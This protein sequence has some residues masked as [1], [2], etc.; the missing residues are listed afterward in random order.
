MDMGVTEEELNML[1]RFLEKNIE[2]IRSTED[3]VGGLSHALTMIAY[4]YPE[5]M[6][7]TPAD[8]LMMQLGEFRKQLREKF[9]EW[10]AA[11]S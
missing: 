10:T 5:L 11:D 3:F 6:D 8:G 4:G 7:P 1:G 9:P 2:N